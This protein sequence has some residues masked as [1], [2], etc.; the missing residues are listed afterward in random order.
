[1]QHGAMDY[2]QK[3]FTEEELVDFA[4][5]LLIK[6]QARLEAQR[7]PTVSVV[8]PAMAE[9]ASAH[10]FCVPGGAFVSGQHAWARIEPGG[11]VRIGLDDFARKALGPFVR[12]SLPAR[13]TKV[14]RGDHLFAV[15][16]GGRTVRFPSPVSGQVA[17]SN[18]ALAGDPGRAGRSPYDR[19]WFCLVQPSDLASELLALRIGKP[20][21]AWYQD[22]IA[23]LR[24]AA[25]TGE[26][27][28]SKFESEFLAPS[29][30]AGAG[31]GGRTGA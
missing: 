1:M 10:E 11:Q 25:A 19:G 31:A 6:R 18:E 20:V 5:R 8:A 7:R 16:R 2:V 27:E 15:G 3:P 9:T 22:E 28:W 23:R 12:V 17:A 24:A 29:V 4:H 21:I 13:G 26:V 30:P 14:R